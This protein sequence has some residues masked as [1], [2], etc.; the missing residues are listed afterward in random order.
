MTDS[1]DPKP[2]FPRDPKTGLSVRQDGDY[3]ASS[4]TGPN[5]KLKIIPP[6]D[7][8]KLVEAGIA[9]SLIPNWDRDD[10][11]SN[12]YCTYRK[13]TPELKQRFLTMLQLHGRTGL[14]ANH[15]GV[16]TET[17]RQHRKKDPEFDAACI[18]ALDLYHETTVAAITHQART[19][20]YDRKW[21][22]EGNLLSERW[23]TEQR[24]REILLKRGDPS[25]TETQKQEVAVVGGAVVVPA[26][27]DSVESWDEVVKRHTG[28]GQSSGAVS[29]GPALKESGAAG[30]R[31]LSEGRVVKRTVV[32]TSGESADD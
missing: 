6:A 9:P 31:A 2:R 21:D 19:G 24:L 8:Q 3:I 14:A 1:S 16:N 25:Y 27:I 32:D 7:M 23:S 29:Q 28:G 5:L 20:M 15:A 11:N 10:P 30:E 13:F 12:W 17:I 26:P 22:K 18:T 4:G